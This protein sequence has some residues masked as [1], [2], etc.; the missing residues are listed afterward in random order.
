MLSFTALQRRLLKAGGL[1]VGFGSLVAI[2]LAGNAMANSL[3]GGGVFASVFAYRQFRRKGAD[4]ALATWTLL[5]VT[6]L[7]A[8]ALAGVGVLGLVIAGEQSSVTGL[9]PLLGLL[10]VGPAIGVAILV[11]P[12]LLALFAGPP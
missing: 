3:P 12:R 5:A 11:R 9:I 7:T 8:L 2:T 1:S 10:V 6:G 4:E